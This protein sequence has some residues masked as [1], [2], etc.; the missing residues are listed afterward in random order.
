MGV[1]D[2]IEDGFNV[3]ADLSTMLEQAFSS[4]AAKP[5]SVEYPNYLRFQSVLEHFKT[6]LCDLQALVDKHNQ[7]A[8]DCIFAQDT[9]RRDIWIDEKDSWREFSCS[10]TSSL[11]KK[12][13]TVSTS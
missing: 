3:T 9:A 12:T 11:N 5:G 4:N 6:N 1:Q 7:E 10:Q 2:H 8:A 13:C